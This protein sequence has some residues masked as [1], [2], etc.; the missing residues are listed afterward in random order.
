MFQL[1]PSDLFRE[2]CRFWWNYKRGAQTSG[3]TVRLRRLTLPAGSARRML[4]SSQFHVSHSTCISCV[5]SISLNIHPMCYVHPIEQMLIE[6]VSRVKYISL[7]MYLKCYMSPIEHASHVLYVSHVLHISHWTCISVLHLSQWTWTSCVICISCV[8]FIPLNMY[9]NVTRISVNKNLV[10]Y[11]YLSEL[12]FHV[13]HVSRWA[14]IS[15][16][17]CILLNT[18]KNGCIQ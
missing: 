10:F 4:V 5:T 16:V 12:V 13:L 15:S 8:K 3:R 9:L 6:I 1:C 14:F 2:C 7:S 17:T 11:M 18:D